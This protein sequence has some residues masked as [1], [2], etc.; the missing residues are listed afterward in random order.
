VGTTS[1]PVEVADVTASWLTEALGRTITGVE[2]VDQHSGTTGR[3][4]IVV[5]DERGD[6]AALFVKLPPFDERQRRFVD[7]VGLGIAEARF[8]RDVAARVPV[9]V[10]DVAFAAFDGTGGYIMVLEDLEASGCRFPSPRD[11]AA[12][13]VAVVDSLVDE[14][15]RLHGAY[16]EH[17]ALE[18][19]LAWVGEGARQAFEG[20][21]RYIGRAVEQFGDTMPPVFRRLGALY[22]ER[23]P[24]IARLYREGPPTLVHGDPHFGNLFVD[25]GRAGFFDWGMTMCRTGMWDVAYV[26]ANSVP[27]EIRRA[28]ESRWL[29]RYRAGLARAG[30]DVD[31]AMLWEQYRLL[32]VYSWSSATSTAAVGSRWQAVEVGQSGMAR[33]TA[34][35][36]DLASVDLLES[37]LT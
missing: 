18:G 29:D 13:V 26:L 16:W 22:V 32:V 23:T 35:V 28:H 2:V 11:D 31:A 33:A 6:P 34:A 20:G 5:R 27:T 17:P 8:Y 30:V 15:A 14:F 7:A 19:E 36:D 24:D 21:G 1:I 4:R 9:R 25:R 12:E 10:P 3:A 37:L